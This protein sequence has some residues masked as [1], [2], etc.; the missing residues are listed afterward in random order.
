MTGSSRRPRAAG[1]AATSTTHRAACQRQRPP[2][3]QHRDRGAAELEHHR[4]AAARLARA[5]RL[6]AHRP[7]AGP[8]DPGRVRRGL[9]RAGRAAARGDGVRL[10]PHP[11]R[12]PEYARGVELGAALAAAGF[13]VITG[14]GPGVHGGGQPRR[15]RGRR[16]LGRARHRAAVRA[17]PQPVGRP[18]GELPLLLRPQ[19]DVRQVRAG[20][21]LPARRVRHARRAVRGARA[22]ADRQGHPLPGRPARHAT[23]GAGCSTGSPAR[24]STTGKISDEG[25]RPVHLTDDVDEAVDDRP[26]WRLCQETWDRAT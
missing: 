2:P 11:A 24:W 3:A 20:V 9:R 6:G 23:T 12:P 10:G 5:R 19:D 7:V 21:R 4:P 26:R 16:A 15:Q 18:R 22:G 13:A 14:G 25:R 17:G 8:A 1:R